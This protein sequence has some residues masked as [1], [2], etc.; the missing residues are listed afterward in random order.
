MVIGVLGALAHSHV[1]VDFKDKHECVI[2]LHLRGTERAVQVQ[3]MK[4]VVVQ[5]TFAK[6]W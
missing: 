5:I 3:V 2:L 1:G 4:H 6:M